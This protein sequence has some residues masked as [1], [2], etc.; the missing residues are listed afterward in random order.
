MRSYT[1]SLIQ[2]RK[3]EGIVRQ[4]AVGTMYFKIE[5]EISFLLKK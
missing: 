5:R 4:I 1:I 2:M 3:I